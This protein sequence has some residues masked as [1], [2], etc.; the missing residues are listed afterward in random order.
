MCVQNKTAADD[1][2]PTPPLSCVGRLRFENFD[3]ETVLSKSTHLMA[4]EGKE[5]DIEED[6]SFGNYKQISFKHIFYLKKI[7]IFI[8][9]VLI[10]KNVWPNKDNF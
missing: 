3:V 6:S 4:S 9:K 10:L 5:Y 8:F 1:D 2:S 7:Y